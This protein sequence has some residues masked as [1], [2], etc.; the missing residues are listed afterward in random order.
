M[1]S[2]IAGGEGNSGFID[3]N[4]FTFPIEGNKEGVEIIDE[5]VDDEDPGFE[6]YEIYEEYFESSCKELATR[7]GFPARAI[8]P[9]TKCITLN[10][11]SI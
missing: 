2:M 7:F 9:E 3:G 4:S 10:V 1:P 5:Y 6:L 11:T 8:K